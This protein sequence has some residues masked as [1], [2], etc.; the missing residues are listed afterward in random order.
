MTKQQVT[1][2]DI[3]SALTQFAQSVDQRFESIDQRFESIDQRF[4]SIDQRFA[5]Q[6]QFNL[7][8]MQR[9]DSLDKRLTTVEETMATKEDIRRIEGTLD[10]YAAKID[11]YATEMTAMQ[12]KI[13]R[14]E[15]ALRFIAKQTGINLET[16]GILPN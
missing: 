13:D 11:N 2:D 14:L 8:I 7:K 1:N 9:F 5:S 16:F 3:M 10:S 15:N 4:E 6:E 12:Y